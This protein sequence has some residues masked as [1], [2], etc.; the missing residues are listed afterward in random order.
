MVIDKVYS[1]FSVCNGICGLIAI[2]LLTRAS[3]EIDF[4]EA[5]GTKTS[6]GTDISNEIGWLIVAEKL[7]LAE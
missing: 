5:Y 7:Y 3:L 1:S 2:I 4:L 6:N